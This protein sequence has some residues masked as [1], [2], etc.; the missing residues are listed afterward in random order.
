MTI[1]IDAAKQF[2][3]N[4]LFVMY[5]VFKNRLHKLE[6]KGN[7]LK[8]LKN[9]TKTTTTIANI[10]PTG[11]KLKTFLLTLGMRQGCHSYYL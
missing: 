9:I 4:V 10:I 2:D 5:S 1:L 6:I 3:K 7:F 11:E 8:Q